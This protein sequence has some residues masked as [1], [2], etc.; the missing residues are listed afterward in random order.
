MERASERG[1]RAEAILAQHSALKLLRDQVSVVRRDIAAKFDTADQTE[2]LSALYSR[3]RSIV[4]AIPRRASTA[5]LTILRS[6]FEALE[7]E[8]SKLLETKKNVPELSGTAAQFERHYYESL[9][10]SLL[11]PKNAKLNDLT[12]RLP[13]SHPPASANGHSSRPLAS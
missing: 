1:E 3:F 5:E 2:A 6:K 7:A 13:G 12:A 4:D 8:L 11:Y 9:T 10:E